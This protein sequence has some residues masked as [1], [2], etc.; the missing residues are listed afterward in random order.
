MTHFVC[1]EAVMYRKIP[2]ISP[3]AYFWSKDLFEK[4]SWGIYTWTNICI[5]KTLFFVQGIVIF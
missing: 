5:L 3:W 1:V 2:I 4:K